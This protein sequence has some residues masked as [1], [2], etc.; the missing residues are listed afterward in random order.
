MLNEVF[1]VVYCE[2]FSCPEGLFLLVVSYTFTV[3]FCLLLFKLSPSTCN[4]LC[5]TLCVNDAI[6]YIRMS[7][8]VQ[9]SSVGGVGVQ[10]GYHR[11]RD[12]PPRFQTHNKTTKQHKY[13]ATRTNSTGMVYFTVCNVIDMLNSDFVSS[14]VTW[15]SDFPFLSDSRHVYAPLLIRIPI[16]ISYNPGGV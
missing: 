5:D 13:S 2:Y 9:G 7:L 8:C 6:M 14:E 16:Q 1:L 10:T 15:L 3:F 4:T 12:L 11:Q